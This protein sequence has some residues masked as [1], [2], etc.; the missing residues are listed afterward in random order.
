MSRFMLGGRL[1]PAWCRFR[2]WA[3][4]AC[5]S[6]PAAAAAEDRSSPRGPFPKT[7]LITTRPRPKRTAPSS[8]T[9]SGRRWSRRSRRSPPT[10]TPRRTPTSADSQRRASCRRGTPCSSPSS[11]TTS[12]T[13]TP[14][15]TGDDPVSFTL[16]MA[17]CPW[18][19]K[20]HLVRDRRAGP[21]IARGRRDAAAEPR[22]PH[23]HV[24]LDAAGEPP[25][26]RQAVARTAR[27]PA[28]R[29]GPRVDR[30]LRRRRR[31]E[32]RARPRATSKD[33]HPATW[34]D[35]CSAGGSTN[36]EGGIKIAYET[37][38]PQRS[39]TAG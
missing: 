34:C 26:A 19:P 28:H 15:P 13:A 35:A 38:P 11:S 12:P 21:Q 17:P 10:S 27:R 32:A 3:G 6:P 9:S 29:E 8:R 14:Q 16:D 25:A 1:R 31:A 36:G 23:R 2:F 5:S 37:G 30:H 7:G 24:R 33:T 18:K 39:S 22:L 4:C 20:H